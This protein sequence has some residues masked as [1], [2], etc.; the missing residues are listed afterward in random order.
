MTDRY[1]HC[2]VCGSAN[3]IGLKLDFHYEAGAARA[4]LKISELYEGYPGVV[5]GGIISTLLDEVMAK[6]VINS[7]LIAFT[8]KLTTSFRKPVPSGQ[9]LVLKGWVVEAKSRT[10][11]TAAELTDASGATYASAEAVFVV[12]KP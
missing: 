8:A 10:L 2:F 6:A 7:G 9:P 3:P 5:H 4:E 1:E 12:P 11:R